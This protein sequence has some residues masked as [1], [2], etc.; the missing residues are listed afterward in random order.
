MRINP[1]D[2]SI[3][4]NHKKHNRAESQSHWYEYGTDKDYQA[5]CR[6]QP[7][8]F[9]GKTENIVFAHYRTAENSGTATKPVYSGIPLTWEEHQHQ[10]QIGQYQFMPR[11]WWEDQVRK[12]LEGWVNGIYT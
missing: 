4:A 9:S 12:H 7:S 8:A 2:P 1:I 11:E 3:R 10:H 6:K 5:W